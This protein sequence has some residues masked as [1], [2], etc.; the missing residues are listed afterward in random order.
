MQFDEDVRPA[1]ADAGI[2]EVHAEW[3]VGDNEHAVRIFLPTARDHI[4]ASLFA[5][6]LTDPNSVEKVLRFTAR[7]ADVYAASEKANLVK[8]VRLRNDLADDGYDLTTKDAN[9]AGFSIN[10]R[11]IA[12]MMK[13]T[14]QEFDKHP[15][16]VPVNA[17]PNIV[18]P[19]ST[20]I[21][22]GPVVHGDVTGTQ[23]AWGNQTV[24]QT[25]HSQAEKIAP[26]FEAVAQAVVKTLERLHEVGLADD[27]RHDAETVANEAL[28]EV[29]QTQPDRGKLRRALNALK[30]YLAPVAFGL[31]TGSAEG[32][33]EW[34]RTAIEQLG[35]PF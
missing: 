24:N 17:D 14:Q 8:I 6:D 12:R 16:S 10:E 27:D 20:T 22:N 15:I 21:Y 18:P 34:A 13:K 9:M 25:Q 23:L 32:A 26:G 28:A 2:D 7:L 1:L 11:E 35:T 19:N 33:Q 4:K 3:N 31:V 29:T 30:G 5:L